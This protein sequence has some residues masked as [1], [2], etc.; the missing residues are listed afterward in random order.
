MRDY[1]ILLFILNYKMGI[2]PQKNCINIGTIN[3]RIKLL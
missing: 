2:I 3:G 1:S